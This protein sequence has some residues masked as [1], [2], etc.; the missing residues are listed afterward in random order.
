MSKIGKKIA[1]W[2]DSQRQ[3][4]QE[5]GITPSAIS[6][7]VTGKRQLPLYRFLQIVNTVKPPQEDVDDIFNFYLEDLG[8]PSSAIRL[9]CA[10]SEIPGSPVEGTVIRDARIAKITELV[11]D[12]DKLSAEA[13]VIVYN[14]IQST[15]KKS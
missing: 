3:V 5:A 1:E 11:M 7:Y 15:R 6:S 12:S 10:G 2:I 4:A 9:L 8:I 13:K 14:I